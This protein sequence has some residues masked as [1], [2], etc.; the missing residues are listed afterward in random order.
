MQTTFGHVY[1]YFIHGMYYCLNF[2]TDRQGA[3]AVLIRAAEPTHG[4]D[5]MIARRGT[6]DV[7]KLTTG[8]GRLCSGFGIDLK[9]NGERI[10]RSIKVKSRKTIPEIATSKR[11]GI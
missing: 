3:G 11:V 5:L 1:V 2:T 4:L 8:P 10:G 7:R 6:G 9:F